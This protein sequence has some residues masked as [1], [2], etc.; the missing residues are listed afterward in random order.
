MARC[1]PFASDGAVQLHVKGVQGVL[2]QIIAIAE[3]EGDTVTDLS[4]SEPTLETL[5]IDLTGRELRD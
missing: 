2:P 4:V 1:A 3:Q 5:F